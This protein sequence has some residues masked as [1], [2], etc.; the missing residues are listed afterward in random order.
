MLRFLSQKLSSMM[1]TRLPAFVHCNLT[2]DSRLHVQTSNPYI[3]D[4]GRLYFPNSA[5]PS[6]L[7]HQFVVSKSSLHV[8]NDTHL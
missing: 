7:Q 1:G 5:L 6:P 2:A 8:K 4:A 3:V